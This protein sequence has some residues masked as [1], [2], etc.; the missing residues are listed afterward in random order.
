ML[1]YY[2]QKISDYEMHYQVN[3][4]IEIRLKKETKDMLVCCVWRSNLN[5]DSKHE[6][7]ERRVSK[8]TEDC[9]EITRIKVRDR[10]EIPCALTRR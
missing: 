5:V 4:I 1:I 3:K 8:E 2:K 6:C 10:R 7:M 9:D